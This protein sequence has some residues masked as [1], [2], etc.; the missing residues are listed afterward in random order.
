MKKLSGFKTLL[1]LFFILILIFIILVYRFKKLDSNEEIFRD[2]FSTQDE[3]IGV[4]DD[5]Y[6]KIDNGKFVA[7]DSTGELFSIYVL[8]V[9][10][11]LYDN[12][13]YIFEE[14]GNIRS[15]DRNNGSEIKSFNL[16]ENIEFAKFY[17]DDI[18]IYS[19]NSAYIMDKK[20]E[21]LS[22][23][24]DLDNPI[25]IDVD[26]EKKAIIEF[27]NL[28]N[29]FYSNFIYINDDE[30]V[31][32][33]STNTETYLFTKI[34][35]N[36]VILVSSSYIYLIENN[37]ITKKILIEDISALDFNEN[38]LA[39][40]NDGNLII[41]D[42]NL[43]E[44][45]RKDLEEDADKLYIRNSSIVIVGEKNLMVFENDNLIKTPIQNVIGSFSNSQ[46]SYI[47]FKDRIEKVNAY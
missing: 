10:Q 25:N 42:E 37:T 38:N 17:N 35:G 36:K 4:I 6:Y 39:I 2:K 20:L 34:I 8:D 1:L 46:A 16:G 5:K 29:T 40:V 44:I 23:I 22:K 24:E 13:I 3:F 11:I 30:I 26:S 43:N 15:I 19:E 47:I 18:L 31:F 41:Y 14:N 32:E 12:L 33:L 9:K 45:S 7:K 28:N 27:K 21:I